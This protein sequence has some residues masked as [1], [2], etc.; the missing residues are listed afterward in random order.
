MVFNLKF[1][2]FK[3]ISY[4]EFYRWTG[5]KNKTFEKIVKIFKEA[6]NQQKYYGGRKNKLLIEDRLL[7]TLEYWREYRTYF[8]LEKVLALA[9]Q[10]VIEILNKLRIF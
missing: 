4:K 7:M 1:I 10:V 9:N 3:D 8:I 6:E 2:E 5:V